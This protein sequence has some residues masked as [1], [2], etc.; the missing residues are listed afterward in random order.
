M[1]EVRQPGAQHPA[2]LREMRYPGALSVGGPVSP[3][4]TRGRE[5][6]TQ[7][8]LVGRILS[9]L[10]AVLLSIPGPAPADTV[11]GF[12]ARLDEAVREVDA[13]LNHGSALGDP[14]ALFPDSDEVVDPGGTMQLD[15]TSLRA[16]WKTIAP[17]GE[18]RRESLQRLRQRL[19]AVRKEVAVAGAPA[20]GT[21]PSAQWK[22]KLAEVMSRPEFTGARPEE[23]WRARLMEWLWEKL[24]FLFPRGAAQAAGSLFRWIIYCLA[25]LALLAV[26]VVLVKA[27]LPLF[28][29]ERGSRHPP[30][31]S[32]PAAT[33]TQA[34]LLA[35]AD[36][37]ARNG[38]LRG[39]AQAI[40]RWMLLGLQRS[41]R[42]EYEPALTNREHLARLKADA[43]AR[44]AFE[45]L[46][47]EFDLVW[48]GL[49]PLA[50]SEF[51]A[52]RA[53]C[54]RVAGGRA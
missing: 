16:E 34:T 18:T 33:E 15:H 50:A 1:P 53:E 8:R 47:R 41:G 46:C 21:V 4:V 40:F 9:I 51:A 28:L 22:E 26:L 39:A 11:S 12:T 13:A 43:A 25:G 44:R 35:L 37:R 17:A 5:N 2:Q 29:R 27:A 23:D 19:M 52:F 49:H 36:T 38:D 48:Y 32:T 20:A 10:T 3:S 31:D 7:A 6:M 14:R 42:L 54:Q 45:E 30:K 24:S